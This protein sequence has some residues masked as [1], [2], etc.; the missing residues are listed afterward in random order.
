MSRLGNTG[1]S[2]LISSARS[3]QTA[4]Q[5]LEDAQQAYIFANGPQDEASHNAYQSFLQS[6]ISSRANSSLPSDQLK[7]L[8]YQKTSQSANHTYVTNQIQNS[9]LDIQRGNQTPQQKESLLRDLTMKAYQTGDQQFGQTLEGQ[10]NSV[11]MANQNAARSQAAQYKSDMHSANETSL[12]DAVSQLKEQASQI[13]EY[14]K[15]TGQTFLKNSDGTPAVDRNG[16]PLSIYAGKL[17]IAD[18]LKQLGQHAADLV[19]SGG[20]SASAARSIGT[21]ANSVIDSNATHQ[22]LVN[23][24]ALQN[25]MA[26]EVAIAH[27]DAN[28]HTYYSAQQSHQ[29]GV[30]AVKG[31]DGKFNFRPNLDPTSATSDYNQKAIDEVKASMKADGLKPIDNPDGTISVVDPKTLQ[32]YNFTIDP[33]NGRALSIHTDANGQQYEVSYQINNNANRGKQDNPFQNVSF[34]ELQAE[35]AASQNKQEALDPTVQKTNYDNMSKLLGIKLTGNANTDNNIIS[36]HIASLEQAAK[37]SQEAAAK[38]S[39][40][41]ALQFS[42]ELAATQKLPIAQSRANSAFQTA[43]VGAPKAL[44]APS[45][46]PSQAYAVKPVGQSP[47][48]NFQ[49]TTQGKTDPG[50]V[51]K[52]IAAAVG[53]NPNMSF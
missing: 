42:N 27:T 46:V 44:V 20:I 47:A 3:T 14:F 2:S 11:V 30:S 29:V 32:S 4:L 25:G 8:N 40:A 38:L 7:A 18:Q 10:Y 24:I 28:G 13:D 6:R 35:D 21:A 15:N 26:P 31:K 45:N 1:V 50:S 41:K 48:E 5:G 37:T 53:Y 51:A 43:G 33:G 34:Q 12:H 52:G 9:A 23:N 16:K 22:A 36:A 49:A 19:G 39:Q 17:L